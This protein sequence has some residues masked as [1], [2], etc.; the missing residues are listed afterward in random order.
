MMA[1]RKYSGSPGYLY[2]FATGH[3]SERFWSS[4]VCEFESVYLPTLEKR[5]L[6]R[7][8]KQETESLTSFRVTEQRGQIS[9]DL[10]C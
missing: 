8:I 3:C 7:L 6:P 9:F 1:K 2:V 10:M 5:P 4:V